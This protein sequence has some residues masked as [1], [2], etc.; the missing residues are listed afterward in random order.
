M[1][2]LI[3]YPVYSIRTVIIVI[4]P[5]MLLRVDEKNICSEEITC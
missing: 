5:K 2:L 1:K 4:G 3:R